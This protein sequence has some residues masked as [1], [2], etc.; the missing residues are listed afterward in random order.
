VRTGSP[1]LKHPH[2]TNCP[3]APISAA[4]PRRV[5]SRL[6]SSH[7]IPAETLSQTQNLGVALGHFNVSDLTIV[8]AVCADAR[9]LGVPVPGAPA[10]RDFCGG[11]VLRR[12]A[13]QESK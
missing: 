3:L 4:N 11:W 1:L 10:F 2:L 13:G 8:Q 7:A 9:E 6:E 12:R 5:K